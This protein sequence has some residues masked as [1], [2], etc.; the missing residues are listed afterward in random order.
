MAR[1]K[2]FFSNLTDSGGEPDV[3]ACAVAR[4]PTCPGQCGSDRRTVV[5]ARR[6]RPGRA[7][8]K[9]WITL[10]C[11]A[12]WLRACPVNTNAIAMPHHLST[13]L[14]MRSCLFHLACIFAAQAYG[15]CPHTQPVAEQIC[16]A[17][18]A[19]SDRPAALTRVSRA[20]MYT[21]RSRTSKTYQGTGLAVPS[22]FRK[23]TLESFIGPGSGTAFR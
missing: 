12:P 11:E 9:R 1:R 22:Q 2:Y 8:T 16:E 13:L 15:P 4:D 5:T 10:E 17:M 23:Q 3:R 6:A 7:K 19:F 18:S 21:S 20:H 14:K